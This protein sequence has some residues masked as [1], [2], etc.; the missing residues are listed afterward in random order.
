[1]HFLTKKSTRV[2]EEMSTVL[3]CVLRLRGIT[4]LEFDVRLVAFR[5]S[6]KSDVNGIILLTLYGTPAMV[7]TKKLYF[8]VSGIT[9]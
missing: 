5:N 1:M 9:V 2:H 3:C 8:S 7:A 4:G 6:S